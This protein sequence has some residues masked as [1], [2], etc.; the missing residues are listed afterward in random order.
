MKGD[1]IKN[2]DNIDINN[3]IIFIKYVYIYF[4]RNINLIYCFIYLIR[5][6]LKK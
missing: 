3:Q 6:G 5:Y 4:I 2:A 1:F